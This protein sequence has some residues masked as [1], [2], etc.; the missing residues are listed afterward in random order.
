MKTK[1][2]NSNRLRLPVIMLLLL[3]AIIVTI[4]G[5]ATSDE[6]SSI[7]WAEPESW[8]QRPSF[9]VPY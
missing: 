9:G 7:P 1:N 3:S 8:E 2:K 6:G 4:S 5:C